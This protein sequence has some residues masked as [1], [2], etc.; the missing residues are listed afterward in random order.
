MNAKVLAQGYFAGE[1]FKDS[2]ER[3]KV[4][5]A[6]VKGFE[7]FQRHLQDS[8]SQGILKFNLAEDEEAFRMAVNA[9]DAHRCILS[10]YEN[11]K[12]S[13]KNCI[14]RNRE[15]TEAE[16]TILEQVL[17]DIHE[18]IREHDIRIYSRY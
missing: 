7:Y 3:E 2:E 8:S 11:I 5:E 10:I 15:V 12:S 14:W 13:V 9:V 18:E 17:D 6:W 16:C 1:E 4:I